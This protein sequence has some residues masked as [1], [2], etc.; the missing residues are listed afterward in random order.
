MDKIILSDVDSICLD[1]Q[2]SFIRWIAEYTD[3]KTDKILADYYNVEDWLDISTED[4]TALID[5]YNDSDYF[6]NIKAYDDAVEVLPKLKADGWDFIAITAIPDLPNLYRSRKANLEKH[7]PGIF[8]DL[9]LVGYNIS[10]FPELCKYDPTFWVDDRFHH[11][12]DGIAAG[13]RS[14]HL[15]RQPGSYSSD[16]SLDN[17]QNFE[18]VLTWHDIYKR[19]P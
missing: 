17:N 5:T 9:V 8:I 14:F 15:L 1:W 11:V 12:K 16:T 6:A 2:E 13:H 19:I 18:R 4:V 3:H 7:F 10:K